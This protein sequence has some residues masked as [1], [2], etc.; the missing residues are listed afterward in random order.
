MKKISG[1]GIALIII[2]TLLVLG[3]VFRFVMANKLVNAATKGD[4]A[5]PPATSGTASSDPVATTQQEGTATTLQ[6]MRRPV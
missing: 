4:T 6:R 3:L 5:T 1:W 2:G